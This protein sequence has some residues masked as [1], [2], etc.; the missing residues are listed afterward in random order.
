MGFKVSASEGCGNSSVEPTNKYLK[1][2]MALFTLHPKLCLA[3]V[4]HTTQT[5]HAN[6]KCKHAMLLAHC[7]FLLQ[8]WRTYG[9]WDV[10]HARDMPQGHQSRTGRS[11]RSMFTGPIFMLS[12]HPGFCC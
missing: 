4:Q 9:N 1:H 8:T 11:G 7:Y 6:D 5:L 10:M 12:I 2:Y 3:T